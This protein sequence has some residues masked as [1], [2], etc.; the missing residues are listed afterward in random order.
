MMSKV[1]VYDY[2][3]TTFGLTFFLIVELAKSH[4]IAC[5]SVIQPS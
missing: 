1:I 3:Q 4:W 5:N 2:N